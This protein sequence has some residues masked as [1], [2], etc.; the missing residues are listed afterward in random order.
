MNHPYTHTLTSASLYTLTFHL[1][2]PTTP[3]P[4]P[5]RLA[6]TRETLSLL[7]CASITFA[8][9]YCLHR[10][11]YG[12]GHSLS[13][14]TTPLSDS[15]S[16]SNTLKSVPD[17]ISEA[18]L[19][20]I[21]TRSR[22]GNAL[23][24][25]ETG[26]LLS[27]CVVLLYAARAQRQYVQIHGSNIKQLKGLNITHLALH[28]ALLV[29]GLAVLQSYIARGAEKGIL[30]I[31]ALFLMNASS[32]P[33]TLRWFLVNF[34]PGRT[35]SIRAVTAVYLASYG[36]ARVGLLWWVLRVFGRERGVG[37]VEAWGRLRWQ[38]RMGMGMMG[39]VNAGWWVS[40]VVRFVG[41]EIGRGKGG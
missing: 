41:R 25:W 22:L 16:T 8:S 14:T 6:R 15:D 9:A 37:V 2:T 18:S 7:H 21:A 1:L 40:G 35:R 11:G 10:H 13:T 30:V 5:L 4:S 31:V 23:T 36:V 33:G 38:C 17:T 32:V 39:A 27:D 26:Y 19:P 20:L 24:A 34:A 29:A 12:Y 28:H 3:T